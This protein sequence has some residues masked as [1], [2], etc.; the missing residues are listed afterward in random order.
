M[1]KLC[2]LLSMVCLFSFLLTSCTTQTDK[3]DET[4]TKESSEE[5]SEL[6]K[7]EKVELEKTL[8]TVEE[9]VYGLINAET[10]EEISAFVTELPDGYAENILETFPHDDYIVSVEKIGEYNQYD[11]FYISV[12][13]ES[14]K[15]FLSTGV[16]LYKST[17]KGYLIETNEEFLDKVAQSCSC[18]SCSGYGN[19]LVRE[20]DC[21]VCNGTGMVYKE[22]A[23]YNKATK[24][25]ESS[26]VDCS[27]CK[28][29]GEA[30]NTTTLC[31][32]CKGAGLVF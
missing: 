17:D 27:G 26:Y 18:P 11:A 13:S 23:E 30:N 3:K 16:Q 10:E 5:V 20:G 19:I 7:E 29:T 31:E 28:G 22:K 24:T 14:D 25:W 2:M 32:T 6:T 1:K 15:E 21:P 9:K 12:E 8:K 4:T